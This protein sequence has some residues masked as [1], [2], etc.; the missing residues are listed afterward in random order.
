MPGEA[1]EAT[2]LKIG[3]CGAVGTNLCGVVD[4][5]LWERILVGVSV[6]YCKF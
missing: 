2:E 3:F 5:V 4:F 1:S 6:E